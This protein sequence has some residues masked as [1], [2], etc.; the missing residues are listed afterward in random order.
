MPGE[1]GAFDG[2]LVED[3]EGA[4]EAEAGGAGVGVGGVAK[5]GF[6]AAEHFGAAFDLAVDFESDGDEVVLDGHGGI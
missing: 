2:V 6:A 3:G 1:N 5:R 4:G